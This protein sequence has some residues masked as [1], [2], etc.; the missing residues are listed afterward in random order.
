MKKKY[1]KPRVELLQ[2]GKTDLLTVSD[3]TDPFEKDL[4]ELN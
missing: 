4:Y 2:C 1:L 3:P